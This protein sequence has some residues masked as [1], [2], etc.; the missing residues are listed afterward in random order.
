MK[1]YKQV[2]LIMFE[3]QIICDAAIA[4]ADNAY[5][6]LGQVKAVCDVLSDAFE[7]KYGS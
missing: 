1:A 7:E 4:N 5:E 2:K 3:K 6:S